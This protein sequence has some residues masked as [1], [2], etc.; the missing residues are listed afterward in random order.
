MYT[1][2]IVRNGYIDIY[3]ISK[4]FSLFFK[5]IYSLVFPRP[6]A[7]VLAGYSIAPPPSPPP[8]AVGRGGGGAMSEGKSY[9]FPI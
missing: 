6:I 2:P 7:G 8:S 5:G 9:T 3:I 4:I 1:E